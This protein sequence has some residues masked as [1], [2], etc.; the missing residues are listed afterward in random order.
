MSL[1][2]VRR[3][4]YIICHWLIVNRRILPEVE[5]YNAECAAR[6]GAGP[7]AGQQSCQRTH[8]SAKNAYIV[9]CLSFELRLRTFGQMAAKFDLLLVVAPITHPLA[10][11]CTVTTF[12]LHTT[13]QTA[14][15]LTSY[16]TH[17]WVATQV[18]A[19]HGTTELCGTDH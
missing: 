15:D 19:V 13:P 14:S 17:C 4:N 18:C 12:K 1:D 2:S 5:G 9:Y 7:R 10:H 11:A 16:S 6:L 3:S 8:G